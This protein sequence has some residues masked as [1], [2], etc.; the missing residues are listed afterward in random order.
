MEGF[1]TQVQ[2]VHSILVHF[3]YL[4]SVMSVYVSTFC[5]Y[6]SDLAYD[7]LTR[8]A[9]RLSVRLSVF[10]VFKTIIHFEYFFR[11]RTSEN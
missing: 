2:R 5:V 7:S 4:M 6:V 1:E 10:V 8:Y 9:Y 11:Y 3:H